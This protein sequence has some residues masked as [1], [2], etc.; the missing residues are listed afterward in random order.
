MA[1]ALT[2]LQHTQTKL[3]L[4]HASLQEEIALAKPALAHLQGFVKDMQDTA[5]RADPRITY[6]GNWVREAISLLQIVTGVLAVQGD[7]TRYV[8]VV[9]AFLTLFFL[10]FLSLPSLYLLPCLSLPLSLYLAFLSLSS[11]PC[12]PLSLALMYGT[13]TISG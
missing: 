3:G 6:L 5:E 10:F 8:G 2:N 12:P 11:L 13:M 9:V 7:E 4:V 1:A